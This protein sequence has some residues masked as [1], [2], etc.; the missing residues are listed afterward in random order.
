[1]RSKDFVLSKVAGA[2]NPGDIFTKYVDRA[3][4]MR[5]VENLGLSFETG[6]ASSAPELTHSIVAG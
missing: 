2:D 6:R 1:M 5:H 3:T 4:L